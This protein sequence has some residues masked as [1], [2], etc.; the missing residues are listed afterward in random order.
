MEKR[1]YLLAA[2]VLLLTG[3]TMASISYLEEHEVALVPKS[4]SKKEDNRQKILVKNDESSSNSEAVTVDGKNIQITA[5]GEFY[6]SGKGKGVTIQVGDQVTEDV[7]LVLDGLEIASISMKSKGTNIIHLAK[8]SKN[9]LSEAE[10]GISATNVTIT[11]AGSLTMTAISKYGIFATEDL[12]VEDGKIAIESQGSGLATL[13]D[14]DPE[15]ANLTINGGEMNL[16]TNS[17]KGN[18]GLVA[19]NQLIINHGNLSVTNSYEGYVGKHVTINGGVSKIVSEDD[20]IVS[21][22]PFYE[23]GTVSDVDIVMNGGEVSILAAGDALDSNG[24]LTVNGGQFALE[25]SSQLDGS[26][27]VE[28]Q[29]QLAGGTLW[30]LGSLIGAEVFHL[31]SQPFLADEFY[32]AKGDRLEVRDA[33]GNVVGTYTSNVGASHILFSSADLKLGEMYTVT[34][35]AGQSVQLTAMTQAY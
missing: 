32:V 14:K 10:T 35:S 7:T 15:Q 22:D 26:L 18:A 31:A 25:T 27:D 3:A 1:L 29:S 8:G 24:S 30:G 34:T 28:G 5:G 20:G 4:V 9:T 16:S 2:V 12:V 33:A 19:G 6:I 23:E 13:H 17:D 11:G 21:K